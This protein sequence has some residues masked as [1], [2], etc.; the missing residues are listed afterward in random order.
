MKQLMA[1]LFLSSFFLIYDYKQKKLLFVFLFFFN[2]HNFLGCPLQ[3]LKKHEVGISSEGLKI[4]NL[5]FIV[6]TWSHCLLNYFIFACYSFLRSFIAFHLINWIPKVASD[7]AELMSHILGASLSW[8]LSW[9]I[10]SKKPIA[11]RA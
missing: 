1:K 7:N 9:P 10:W 6:A 2:N 3:L 5:S 4:R 8:T 11:S